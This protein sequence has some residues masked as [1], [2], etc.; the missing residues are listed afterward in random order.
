MFTRSPWVAVTLYSPS[1]IGINLGFHLSHG[2]SFSLL[3]PIPIP[4]PIR[5]RIPVLSFT[6]ILPL[7]PTIPFIIYSLRPNQDLPIQPFIPFLLLPMEDTGLNNDAEPEISAVILDLDGT[8]LNTEVASRGVLREFL[9]SYGKVLITDNEHRRVGKTQKESAIAIVKNYELPLT[10][11]QLI[12]QITPMYRSKW[13]DAKAL[14]GANRLIRH[15]HKHQV[16]LA[17][18]SNSSREYIEAKISYQKGWKECFSV[19]LGSDQVPMGKP[20]PD[21]FLEGAKRM[22]VDS[23][24]CLVIEDSLIGVKAAKAAGMK[25]VVVPSQSEADSAAL[26]DFVLHSLLEFQPEL[27]GLPKFDDWV[28]KALPVDPIFFD[29]Q[30]IDGFLADCSEEDDSPNVLPD[31][32]CG[33]FFGWAVSS[34]GDFKVVASIGREFSSA[35]QTKIQLCSTDGRVEHL[36]AD[37]MHF[38]LV[39]YIRGFSSKG[40]KHL[41]SDISENDVS[42]AKSALELPIFRYP[43]SNGL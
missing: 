24:E 40:S 5:I 18:A 11:E 27:W 17:L 33:V 23:S 1:G 37:R 31:Q 25:V 32:V 36:S 28:D 6:I 3:F 20:S 39:G 34:P 38:A 19:I 9:A 21:L 7:L 22:A 26:A 41:N 15:L 2:E 12:A 4:F 10:P 16:P 42:I 14:P 13:K 29:G 30:V 43:V 35:F 8:L